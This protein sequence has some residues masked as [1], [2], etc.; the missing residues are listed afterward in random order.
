VAVVNPPFKVTWRSGW[1]SPSLLLSISFAVSP[2][3][4]V[5]GK[6]QVIQVFWA[7]RRFDGTRIGTLEIPVDGGSFDACVDAGRNSP[8]VLLQGR[9][10]AH[11]TK[12]YFYSADRLEEEVYGCHIRLNDRPDAVRLHMISEFETC[13]VLTNLDGHGTDRILAAYRWGFTCR[14]PLKD[15]EYSH[16]RVGGAPVDF[17]DTAPRTSAMFKAIVAHDY[18]DYAFDEF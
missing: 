2:C 9:D 17:P 12:P 8:A 10:P 13:I 15:P 11:P 4:D 16:A 3:H 6:L 7:T 1:I 5:L 14:A 18:P